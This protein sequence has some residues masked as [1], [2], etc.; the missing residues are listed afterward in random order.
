MACAVLATIGSGPALADTIRV[1]YVPTTDGL[2][3]FVAK[4]QGFFANRGLGV[5][6]TVAPN[7][8]VMISAL[9]SGSSDVAHTVLI[10]VLAAI[11]AGIKL[12]VFAGASGFPTIQPPTVGV[13]AR[14]DSGIKSPMDLK[15]KTI[16][17]VGLEA[18]HQ[19][20]VQRWMRENDADFKS[21]RFVEVPFPQMQDLLSAGNVDA[22]VSV[23]PFYSRMINAGVGYTFG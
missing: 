12:S 7:P 22:V 2:T 4:D 19:V 20:M 23:D 18:Y 17:V 9:A 1:N 21:V 11:Q 15:G 13:I 10:P 3:L 8:S 5:K 14:K 6:L 16:G